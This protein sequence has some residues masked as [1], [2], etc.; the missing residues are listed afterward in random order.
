MTARQAAN[1]EAEAPFKRRAPQRAANLK[2]L[3]DLRSSEALPHSTRLAEGTRQLG[4]FHAVGELLRVRGS[5][6]RPEDLR[7]D[8]HQPPTGCHL[9]P[10]RATVPRVGTTTLP[11]SGELRLG[12]WFMA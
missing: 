6:D 3:H 5:K 7:E 9:P 11:I 4:R 1:R 12:T 10:R 8:R 2:H